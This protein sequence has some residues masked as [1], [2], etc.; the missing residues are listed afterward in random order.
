MKTFPFPDVGWLAFSYPAV[1]VLREQL[2]DQNLLKLPF[3]LLWGVRVNK[4]KG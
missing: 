2:V 3:K 4:G 1:P